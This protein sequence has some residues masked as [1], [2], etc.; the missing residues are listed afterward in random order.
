MGRDSLEDIDSEFYRDL[1][2]VIIVGVKA[3]KT[4][5]VRT[6]IYDK[7]E[8]R[9]VLTTAMIMSVSTDFK[10]ISNDGVDNLH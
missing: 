3:N 8:F 10:D 6:N 7:Q 1:D 9:D 5:N 4:V 2:K